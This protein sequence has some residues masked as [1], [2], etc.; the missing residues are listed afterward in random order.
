MSEGEA[1]PKQRLGTSG[2]GPV[3]GQAGQDACRTP[4]LTWARQAGYC[5][6]LFRA[7]SMGLGPEGLRGCGGDFAVLTNAFPFFLDEVAR[8]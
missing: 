3:W 5:Y 6:H 2:P 7:W 4:L 8:P 1:L